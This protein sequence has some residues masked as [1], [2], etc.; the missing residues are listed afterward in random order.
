MSAKS[1]IPHEAIKPKWRSKLT[2]FSL[3]IAMGLVLAILP[4]FVSDYIQ[5][6]IIKIFAFGI[7]A[8]S[9]NILWGYTGLFS[10]GHAVYF[11]ISGYTVG[12]LAVKLGFENFWI[13]AFAGIAI[14]AV[15]AAIM[16][17]LALRV[18]DTYFLLV[19]LAMGELFSSLALKMRTLTNG[20]NGLSGIRFPNL[21]FLKMDEISFYYLSLIIF[22]LCLFLVFRFIKSPFGQVLQGIRENEPRMTALGYNVWLHKYIAFIISAVFAGIGGIVFAY[23]N[24]V[25]APAHLG[26]MTSTEAMLMVII[27]SCT[28]PFGPALGAGIVVLLEHISSLY[29]PERWPMILGAA[30]IIAVVFLPGGVGASFMKYWQKVTR[31]STKG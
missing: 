3:F 4:P 17:I 29:S 6:M 21:G 11:G 8:V 25:M 9:L 24:G 23:Y 14:A 1:S 26:I 13:A 19:T 2:Y 16:A 15:L 5:S 7:F 12:I 31:G 28:T 20:S 18:A 10:L 27:G 30:F 22:I